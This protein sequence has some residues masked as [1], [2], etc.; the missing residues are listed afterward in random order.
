MLGEGGGVVYVWTGAAAVAHEQK[1]Q[2]TN[3]TFACVSSPDV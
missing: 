3:S 2:R 1:L